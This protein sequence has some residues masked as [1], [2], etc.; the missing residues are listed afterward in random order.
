[1][2][3]PP[4]TPASAPITPETRII[5]SQALLGTQRTAIIEH[6]GVRYT[7]QETR[8]GKLILTK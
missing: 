1:M 6:N 7:L 4:P 5:D 3:T 8:Q 2:T